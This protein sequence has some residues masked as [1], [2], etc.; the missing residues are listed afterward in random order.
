P[1]S[2]E[3]KN[4]GYSTSVAALRLPFRA[5]GQCEPGVTGACSCADPATAVIDHNTSKCRVCVGAGDGRGEIQGARDAGLVGGAQPPLPPPPTAYFPP[6]PGTPP[7]KSDRDRAASFARRIRSR[8]PA[9]SSSA[10]LSAAATRPCV[11]KTQA[12]G[13]RVPPLL[14]I[15]SAPAASGSSS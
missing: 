1:A 6:D 4:G 10:P 5:A 14:R 7:S 13:Q 11:G 8:S 15:N 2:G 9:F 3:D 12:V